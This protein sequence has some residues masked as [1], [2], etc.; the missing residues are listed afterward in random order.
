M[1]ATIPAMRAT[2]L[3]SKRTYEQKKGK[4]QAARGRGLSRKER[5]L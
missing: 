4:G 2:E 5:E 1:G 3:E